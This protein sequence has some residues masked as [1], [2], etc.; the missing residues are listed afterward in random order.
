[1]NAAF[2]VVA[3]LSVLYIN[4]YVHPDKSQKKPKENSESGRVVQTNFLLLIFFTVSSK[5]LS[6]F[7]MKSLKSEST[8]YIHKRGNSNRSKAASK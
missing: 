5:I 7:L 6:L 1:M 4:G 8:I 2:A 3:D